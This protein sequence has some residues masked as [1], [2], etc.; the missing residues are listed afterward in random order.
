LTGREIRDL[1]RDWILAGNQI[2]CVKETRETYRDQ[3]HFHYDITIKSLDLDDFP[4]GL[5]VYM[6]LANCDETAPSVLL[7]SAHPPDKSN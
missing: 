4:S 7:L 5:Y 3:R 2:K 1:A 6:Q